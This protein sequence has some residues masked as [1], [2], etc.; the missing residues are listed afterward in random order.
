MTQHGFNLVI[1]LKSDDELRGEKNGAGDEWP[2]LGPSRRPIQLIGA[3][4]VCSC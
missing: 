2:T 4:S 1:E 3:F